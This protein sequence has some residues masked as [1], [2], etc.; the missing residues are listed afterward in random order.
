MGARQGSY[1]ELVPVH[2]EW[3]AERRVPRTPDGTCTFLTFTNLLTFPDV[4]IQVWDKVIPVTART[5]TG[6]DK[7][8]VWPMMAALWPGY[9]ENQAG[10][11]RDIPVVLLHPR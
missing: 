10:T 9:D 1:K 11:T 7:K 4:D 5:G 8:R 2:P 3:S 6:A